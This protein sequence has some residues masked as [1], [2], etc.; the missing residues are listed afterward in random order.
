M[1]TAGF[2]HTA[3]VHVATFQRLMDELAPDWVVRHLVDESLLADARVEGV[4]P[5]IT[6]RVRARLAELATE[7]ADVIVC[8]CSTIGATA[9]ESG[10]EKTS[11]REPSAEETGAKET[12]TDSRARK[13][14]AIPVFRVDRPMADTAVSDGG[15]I[16]VVATVESTLEPTLTLLRDSATRAG[17]RVTLVPSLC[18]GAWA[19]FEAGEFE[20]Y[21]QEIADHVRT[22]A[23]EADVIVLA[24]ASMTPAADRLTGL[25]VLTSP[26]AAVTRAISELSVSQPAPPPRSST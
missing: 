10:T 14:V 3:D 12:S 13:A 23:G 7:G 6:A 24:Q 22:I 11:A 18:A 5:E 2:L 15:R 17:T 1:P 26:R 9:E 8:T 20:R 21:Y 4:T 25:N 16:A 19:H